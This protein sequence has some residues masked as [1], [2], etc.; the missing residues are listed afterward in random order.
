MTP[1]ELPLALGD[2]G[3]AHISTQLPVALCDR[4]AMTAR[5]AVCDEPEPGGG[6]TTATPLVTASGDIPA[7][8]EGARLAA[9]LE[10]VTRALAAA[11]AGGAGAA[12]LRAA[13][14]RERLDALEQAL[15]AARDLC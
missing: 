13:I 11:G 12:A 7:T 6:A 10:E 5:G 1:T 4:G 3:A 14:S 2:R 9:A 8:T 15:A